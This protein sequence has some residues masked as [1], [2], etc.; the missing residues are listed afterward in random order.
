MVGN[1]KLHKALARPS[2]IDLPQVIHYRFAI[3]GED[4]TVCCAEHTGGPRLDLRQQIQGRLALAW[5]SP[6]DTCAD[7]SKTY[8]IQGNVK[9]KKAACLPEQNTTG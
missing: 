9:T 2:G 7:K 3:L 1:G 6:N 4:Q 8:L 5:P